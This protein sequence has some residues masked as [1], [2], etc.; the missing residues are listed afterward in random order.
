MFDDLAD[1]LEAML[2]WPTAIP[3]TFV[4]GLHMQ[5]FGCCRHATSLLSTLVVLLSIGFNSSISSL[6]TSCNGL[7]CICWVDPA[8]NFHKRSLTKSLLSASSVCS[9]RISA[10]K[11]AE[12]KHLLFRF[13]VLKLFQPRHCNFL[14][15]S[16][17]DSQLASSKWIYD[18]KS[19]WDT[20]WTLLQVLWDSSLFSFLFCRLED[21]FIWLKSK[22]LYNYQNC[23]ADI[24]VV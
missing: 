19:K 6:D 20:T 17:Q 22:Q 8:S 3:I 1:Q 13:T 24:I 11:I 4:W 23:S 7:W 9:D 14:L 12:C 15:C 2:D 10:V 16:D 5:V 18:V 21:P